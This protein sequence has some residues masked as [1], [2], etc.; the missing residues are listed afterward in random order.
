M[1]QTLQYGVTRAQES[2][3]V[4]SHMICEETSKI[5]FF[6]D[7]VALTRDGG[8]WKPAPEGVI[9]AQNSGIRCIC[10]ADAAVDRYRSANRMFL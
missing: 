10:E 1:S 7:S 9:R 2:G 5:G 6:C 8:R 3:A 4:N